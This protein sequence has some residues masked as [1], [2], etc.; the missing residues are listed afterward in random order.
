MAHGSI[1]SFESLFFNKEKREVVK[2]LLVNIL[3]LD[4]D[5][6]GTLKRVA[7]V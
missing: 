6:L 7:N 5:S 4:Y 2:G 3:T 1:S